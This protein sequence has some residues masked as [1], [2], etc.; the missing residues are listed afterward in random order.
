MNFLILLVALAPAIALT[1]VV[2][3]RDKEHP[4]PLKWIFIAVGLGVLV[5]AALMAFGWLILPDIEVESFFT[6]LLHSFL[7]AAIPEE[8][9]KFL[10]LYWIAK[11]CKEFD[12]F[13]DG[14]VY[15][16]CIGMGFAGLE[17]IG[18]LF[19]SSVGWISTGIVRG[20]FSVPAHYFFAV[21]MGAMFSYGWFGYGDRKKY[22][23]YALLLPILIHGIFDTLI[24]TAS[25]SPDFL[26]LILILFLVFFR[27]VRKQV[28]RLTIHTLN[29]DKY[30]TPPPIPRQF[31]RR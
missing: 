11:N 1:L 23:S 3:N 19:I 29:L 15:A 16:V 25:V 26:G 7:C 5:A 10:A 24:Y 20:L 2:L 14:I 17:N 22:L 4:E 31:N 21:V 27:Q 13:F 6:A 28:R 30:P 8:G 12:E 9:L 18:Y